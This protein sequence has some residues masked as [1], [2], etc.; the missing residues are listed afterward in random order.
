M[1]KAAISSIFLTPDGSNNQSTQNT[2]RPA[3]AP[4]NNST[5]S[6]QQP[7]R[8]TFAASIGQ[9]TAAAQS[10][11]GVRI[12]LTNLKSTTRFE[13]LHESIQNEIIQ[14]DS[15]ILSQASLADECASLLPKIADLTKTIPT[16][17]EYCERKLQA[18]QDSLETDAAAIDANK[19]LVRADA[20]DA[21]RSFK[22]IHTLR[23]PSQYHVT[24]LWSAAAAAA[25]PTP[26][27][28]SDGEIVD[29]EKDSADLVAYF[30][31]QAD[32]MAKKLDAFK[33]NL[34]EV[35]EY[36]AGVEVQT[37]AQMQSARMGKA[38]GG[39]RS[40]EDKV[41][42]LAGV[43]REFEGG[44]L[45]VAGS[46]GAARE[47]VQKAMLAEGRMGGRWGRR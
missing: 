39:A 9:Y 3:F 41:R 6:A 24:G 18:A 20:A 30:S 44:I 33:R 32:E 7:Q 25:G 12:D 26:G 47:Q 2:Q 37:V 21:R 22:A 28:L 34:G 45:T 16:D 31:A 42:E 46:V 4:L 29:A 5:Y 43:L 13:E 27:A 15:F 35:E 40:A 10:V 19:R 1:H 11:P 38:E 36:L 14:L 8:S 17:V 23:M